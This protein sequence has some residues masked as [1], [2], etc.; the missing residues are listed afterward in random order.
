MLVLK[1]YIFEFSFPKQKIEKEITYSAAQNQSV[2]KDL[3]G[4]MEKKE[5]FTVLLGKIR[6]SLFIKTLTDRWSLDT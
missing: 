4:S 1:R 5:D 3:C 2:E 6:I